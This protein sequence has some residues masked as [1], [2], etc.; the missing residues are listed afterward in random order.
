[1]KIKKLSKTI[2]SVLVILSMLASIPVF[3]EEPDKTGL[4][5]D[6]IDSLCETL[7]ELSYEEY[8]NYYYNDAGYLV[9]N[10]LDSPEQTEAVNRLLSTVQVHLNTGVILQTVR[11]S[12]QE[13]L[14]AADILSENWESIGIYGMYPESVDNKLH[15]GLP[16]I[17]EENRAKIESLVPADMIEYYVQEGPLTVITD[18]SSENRA[19]TNGVT[20]RA[21]MNLNPGDYFPS[22][23]TG[24]FGFGC[25]YNGN[26]GYLT[27]A[28]VVGVN[29]T[30]FVDGY[31]FGTCT[32]S[33]YNETQDI[34][35]VKR[36][37]ATRGMTNTTPDGHTVPLGSYKRPA[38]FTDTYLYGDYSGYQTG[39]V[40]TQYYEGDIDEMDGSKFHVKDMMLITNPA[41]KGD[42]GG[43]VWCDAGPI[44]I[45]KASV[46][47]TQ[48]NYCIVMPLASATQFSS[49]R[50]F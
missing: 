28:H 37:D 40:R 31:N 16:E 13:L 15:I 48:G 38:R 4:S 24:T 17:S 25:Y 26:Y 11:Y 44:G 45:V 23:N 12:F 32:V 9:I 6:E 19:A 8:G 7:D 22:G 20:P 34:A 39:E 49:L 1:M 30:V 43:P 27:A 10:I 29:T 2:L 33:L 14:D 41:S 47:T 5:E 46:P 36:Y 3:A 21:N 18:E 35:F 42:S 50:T